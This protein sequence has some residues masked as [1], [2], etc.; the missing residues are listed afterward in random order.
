MSP[1]TRKFGALVACLVVSAALTGPVWGVPIP[2]TMQS[3]TFDQLGADALAAGPL[4]EPYEHSMVIDGQTVVTFAGTFTSEVFTRTDGNYLYLYQAVNDGPSVLEKLGILPFYAMDT[5]DAG[6]VTG[7]AP[8][9]FQTGGRLPIG[10]VYESAAGIPPTVGYDYQ[11][12]PGYAVPG[13]GYTALF[14]LISPNP[15]VLGE[16]HMIDTGVDHVPAWVAEVPEPA[17]LG[18]LSAGLLGLVARK[19]RRA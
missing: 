8:S 14:Y 4:T 6:V 2:F 13:G 11:S 12:V 10:G 19:R 17:T 15:P 18:L 5:G 7:T 3:K 1:R 9:P 16:A